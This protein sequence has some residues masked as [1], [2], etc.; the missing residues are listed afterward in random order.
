MSKDVSGFAG[1]IR[2]GRRGQFEG[3]GFITDSA[4]N[5]SSPGGG[6]SSPRVTELTEQSG[7]WF[8]FTLIFFQVQ[9]H[10]LGNRKTSI[11]RSL[12]P[13]TKPCSCG[14][15]GTSPL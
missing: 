14:S 2:Q 6:L 7:A 10:P 11:N 5:R 1:R 15:P 13:K 12:N 9:S 8:F 3:T 4:A